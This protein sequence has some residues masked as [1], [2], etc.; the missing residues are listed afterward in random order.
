MRT[1]MTFLLT[2]VLTPCLLQGSEA[3]CEARAYHY[4]EPEN[5]PGS[6]TG[7]CPCP[8]CTLTQEGE[9]TYNR[10]ILKLDGTYTCY[11]P[12][13][14]ETRNKPAYIDWIECDETCGFATCVINSPVTVAIMDCVQTP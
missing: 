3:T 11:H 8:V 7:Y 5:N 14:C 2:L 9:I 10:L 4:E 1:A 13:I 6:Y 12:R